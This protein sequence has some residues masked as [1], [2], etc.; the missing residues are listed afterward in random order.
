MMES[1]LALTAMAEQRRHSL[2]LRLVELERQVMEARQV[3]LELQMHHGDQGEDSED[4]VE[5]GNKK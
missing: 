5:P 1:V 3:L 4:D 2:N